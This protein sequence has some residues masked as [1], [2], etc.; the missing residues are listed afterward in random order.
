MNY[1]KVKDVI[2]HKITNR[3][4]P[5]VYVLINNNKNITSKLLKFDSKKDT[6][7][8]ITVFNNKHHIDIFK[9]E[10]YTIEKI[11][12]FNLIDHQNKNILI[13][14]DIY[15]DIIE[16]HTVIDAISIDL[17]SHSIFHNSIDDTVE[18]NF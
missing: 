9:N 4:K 3:L 8:Y 15:C 7:H 12:L 6:A 5:E 2:F 14:D 1:I 16:K 11:D 10:H 17:H 13:I 18:N